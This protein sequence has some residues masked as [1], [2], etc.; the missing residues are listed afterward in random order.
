MKLKL[1]LELGGNLNANL[2]TDGQAI[3][4]IG[5]MMKRFCVTTN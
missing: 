3:N 2:Q 4:F 5:K 1:V